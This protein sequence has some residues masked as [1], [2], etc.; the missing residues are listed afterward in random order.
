[1]AAE[2]LVSQDQAATADCR[3]PPTACFQIRDRI[4]EL[5]RV[6]ASSLVD[7]PKNWRRHPKVQSEALRGLLQEI[8][9]ANA[10][11]VRELADGRLMLIDGHLRAHTTPD[12]EVPVLVLDV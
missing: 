5:R 12:T 6:R 8:G 11:L 3:Q 7:N 2:S 10:L 1:M 4:S 9:Y